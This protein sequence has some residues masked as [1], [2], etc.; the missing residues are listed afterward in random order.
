MF[1]ASQ[2]TMKSLVGL[3]C[4]STRVETN[5]SLVKSN[6]DWHSGIQTKG[7]FLPLRGCKG[8]A[9]WEMAG[10]NF[11]R[12]VTVPKKQQISFW[13]QGVAHLQIDLALLRDTTWPSLR[14]KLPKKVTLD[15]KN[16]H[17]LGLMNR[18]AL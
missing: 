6:A 13:L 3:A 14:T 12:K 17:L 1:D 18:Q 4:L 10:K 7:A 11:L 16:L 9:S 5:T 2:A 8:K 15:L